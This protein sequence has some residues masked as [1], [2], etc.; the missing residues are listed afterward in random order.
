[1]D[2]IINC[3][4]YVEY[5]KKEIKKENISPYLV[6]INASDDKSS[7][8][9]LKNKEKL[10]KELNFKLRVIK[11]DKDVKEEEIIKKINELNKDNS[12]NGIIIQLPIYEH[13]NKDLLINSIDNFKDID[14]LTIVNKGA[15]SNNIPM[16]IP[17]TA[18]GIIELLNYNK[19]SI[20]GRN[21]VILG[22]SELVGKP[23]YEL[24]LQ[25]DATVTICHSKTKDITEYTKRADILVVAIGKPKY[26]NKDMIKKDSI[27]IDVGINKV[28]DKI[29]GDIDYKDVI[30]KCKKITKVPNGIG[31]VTTITLANN[32]IK[33]YK[34][35]K[36]LNKY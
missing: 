2:K 36:E 29:C 25:K 6:I 32:L 12:V 35:Q 21:V 13:L 16:F 17:C 1:M 4:E 20:S 26:I 8:I 22:R 30:N 11:Y 24:M 14:G 31:I 27:L 19:I 9:Y 5:L 10:F 18:K 3:T 34:I 23:L 28:K 15:L 7:E 33:A